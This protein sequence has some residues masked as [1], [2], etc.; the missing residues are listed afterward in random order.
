MGLGHVYFH[1]GKF[2]EASDAL[3]TALT[4]ARAQHNPEAM[5]AVYLILNLSL[6][7]QSRFAEAIALGEEL[8]LSGPPEL[9]ACGEFIWGT[10]LSIESAYP[11]DAEHHLRAAEK[12]ILQRMPT[13]YTSKLTLTLIK[14]QLAGVTGQQGQ[15]AQSVSLYWEALALVRENEATLDL[16]RHIMLYNDLAYQLH[17][18]GDPSAASYVQAGIELAREKGS[19]THLPYLLSTLGEIALAQ[20][21]LEQAER[22][23]SEGLTLAEAVP[24][25]ER[26]AGLKANLGLVYRQRQQPEEAKKHLLDA[27]ARADQLGTRHLAVRIRIW[28]APLYPSTSAKTV[29]QEARQVAENSGFSGLLEEIVQLEQTLNLS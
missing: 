16:L 13:A 17:L 10:A 26:I 14:Y 25:P 27:L 23:F 9:A 28:L 19:L 5:E 2:P 4:V 18:L 6:L 1:S 21:D 7:P 3:R 22:Y 29:L 12:L 15:T 8:C 24:V 11:V 20:E